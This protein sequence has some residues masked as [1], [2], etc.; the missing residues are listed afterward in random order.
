MSPPFLL[1]VDALLTILL[2][3]DLCRD[4]ELLTVGRAWSCERC[5][6]E[7]DRNAIEALMIDSIQR[8]AVSYQLQ[9]LRCGRCKQIKSDNLRIHCECSGEYVMSETKANLLR[10]LQVTGNVA[11]AHSLQTVTACIESLRAMIG[12]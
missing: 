7:Y 12:N 1:L 8:R 3:L 4:V 9:D 10:R 2:D 6:A 11:E 5:G